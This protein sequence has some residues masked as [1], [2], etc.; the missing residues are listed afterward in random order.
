MK[1]LVRRWLRHTDMVFVLPTLLHLVV[2]A[3]LMFLLMLT[4]LTAVAKEISTDIYGA[5]GD[6]KTLNT[7][8]IQKAID[9]AAKEGDTLIFPAGTY[10]TGALFLKTGVMLRLDKG[11]TLLGSQNI[12]DY[13]VMPT[14]VAGIEMSWPAA[15]INVYEQSKVAITGE[16][17]IDGD[18]KVF[19]E[20]YW[21]LRKA[22]EPR[23]LRWASDYDAG[24]PRLLQIYKA[25]DVRVGDGLLLRRS[26]FWT[27]HICYSSKVVVDR[28]TIRNNE[29]GHGPSTD[30]ID[31]DSSKDILV[32]HADI[33]VNDDAIVL[34]AGRDSDGLRVNR[35]TEDV[36]IRDI[37]VREAVAG[38]SFGS[39]TS[40]G[41]RRIEAYRFTVMKDVPVGI[42]FKSAHTRGGFGEDLNIHDFVM[43]DVPVVLRVIM[44][45]NPQYSYAKIPDDVKDVPAYWKVLVTPVPEKD[46]ISRLRRVNISG[47]KA[48]GAKTAFEIEGYAQAP[49]EDFNLSR[50]DIEASS[51]G[52]IRY[53]RRWK[54]SDSRLVFED[55]KPVQIS[56]DS[57]VSGLTANSKTS[58]LAK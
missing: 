58:D 12:Q 18:G 54:L 2:A 36:V 48:R 4:S 19:W 26:G 28:L 1:S 30:G 37:T 38:L 42:L 50:L 41:F 7:L 57:E 43:N 21:K 15:L 34:K 10:L 52:F 35:P 16:G 40:G 51:G 56:V 23:G 47:I 53:V 45:W 6:G 39:E 13:P 46:G 29:G 31:I 5:K 44:N 3:V 11:V 14:R 20:S 33:A 22:Y 17:V 27:L 49:L 8:A 24:R 55:G 25:S 9:A 32:Q